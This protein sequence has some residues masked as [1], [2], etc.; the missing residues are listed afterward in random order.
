LSA[1]A[2]FGCV[3]LVTLAGVGL[4]MLARPALAHS[5]M[6]MIGLEAVPQA[7]AHSF[8]TARVAPL[9][10]TRCISCHGA[11]R[12]KASLRLDS[13]AAVLL[14]GKHGAVVRPG[15]ARNS[16]LFTRISLPA[17]DERAMP[18][19]GKAPL[20]EDEK[21]VIRLWISH[22]ASGS[23]RD[24]PGAPRPVVEVEIPNLD[25][26]ATQKQRAP[27]AVLVRRLQ[28]RFPGV[29]TYEAQASANLEINA[30]LKGQAF[31][32]ADLQALASLSARIVRADLSGT[33]VTDASAPVLAAMPML[34][35]L[36]LPGTK[37]SDAVIPAL[38]SVKSLRSLSVV[39]TSVT[40][41]ALAPLKA[42]G[43]AVY[44][45]GDGS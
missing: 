3:V 5:A 44:G 12:E 19:S 11:R 35:T 8:Y 42:R 7:D 22:G 21:T 14:G 39:D 29:I 6:Q 2:Y 28:D 27:L 24:I 16:E 15:D 10:D 18:P 25:P 32:D 9:F 36:R 41:K 20:T 30:S 40:A 23:L 17:S 13:F 4:A 45:G 31:G 26:A 34:K 43:V 38:E 1:A 33:A 37:I